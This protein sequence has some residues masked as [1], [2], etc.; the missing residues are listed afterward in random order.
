MFHGTTIYSRLVLLSCRRFAKHRRGGAPE[1]LPQS[2]PSSRRAAQWPCTHSSS[3]RRRPDMRSSSSCAP[4][5]SPRLTWAASTQ[6]KSWAPGRS[7]SA[8]MRSIHAAASVGRASAA[9]ALATADKARAEAC[10][11]PS[12]MRSSCCEAYVG[13]PSCAS[14]SIASSVR[15]GARG[16]GSGA[17]SGASAGTVDTTGAGAGAGERGGTSDEHSPEHSPELELASAPPREAAFQP[18]AVGGLLVLLE[19]VLRCLIGDRP[20]RLVFIT[21]MAYRPPKMT[22]KSSAAAR[23]IP[24]PKVRRRKASSG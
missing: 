24:R 18:S 16:A 22:I 6:S 3:R 9:C 10:P 17:G 2:P 5:R 14:C 13:L 11:P 8:S 23:K 12:S 7:P 1:V 21:D 15:R 20:P 19:R 4:C